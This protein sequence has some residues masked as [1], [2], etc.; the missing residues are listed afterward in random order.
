MSPHGFLSALIQCQAPIASA[1]PEAVAK[2]WRTRKYMK[3]PSRNHQMFHQMFPRLHHPIWSEYPNGISGTS[4]IWAYTKSWDSSCWRLRRVWLVICRDFQMRFYDQWCHDHDKQGAMD[5]EMMKLDCLRQN[6]WKR[7]L[8]H[9]HSGPYTLCGKCTSCVVFERNKIGTSDLFA[10]NT[11]L[12]TWAQ[13]RQ[14]R[15]RSSWM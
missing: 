13:C 2:T 7:L 14:W 6:Q 9:C 15:S 3:I 4:S 11:M 1:K 5:L 12:H 8:Q 10:G